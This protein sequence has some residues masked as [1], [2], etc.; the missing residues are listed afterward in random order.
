[1]KK[2][3]LVKAFTLIAALMAVCFAVGCSSSASI[4]EPSKVEA[5]QETETTVSTTNGVLT[6]PVVLNT[7]NGSAVGDVDGSAIVTIPTGTQVLNQDGT[8]YDGDVTIKTTW[9]DGDSEAT[10]PG[11]SFTNVEIN[12]GEPTTIATDGFV[13]VEIADADGNPVKLSEYAEIEITSA[14]VA[15]NRLLDLVAPN[16]AHAGFGIFNVLFRC[17]VEGCTFKPVTKCLSITSSL[18]V[19]FSGTIIKFKTGGVFVINYIFPSGS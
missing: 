19:C 17:L 1:M 11:G 16:K 3:R 8:V 9:N 4:N 10:F 12:G 14:A 18:D 15:N 7:T 2:F 6:E 13:K 5:Y